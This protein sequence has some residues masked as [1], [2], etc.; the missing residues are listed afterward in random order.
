V[1]AAGTADLTPRSLVWATDLDVLPLNHEVR[2]RDGYLV[3]RSPSNPT[4]YWGNLLLFDQPPAVGDRDRWER[5]FQAEFADQPLTRHRAF[6]WDQTQDALGLARAEFLG[7]GYTLER[8]V[9]LVAAA[10]RIRPHARANQEVTTRPLAPRGDEPLWDQVVEMQVDG[11]DAQRFTEDAHRSF[12]RRRQ[13]DLRDLFAAGRGDWYV[14]LNGDEV[15]GSCG[16]VVTGGRGR[17][18]AV[19]TAPAH[20][21]RGICSRLL[22]D[23]ARHAA[24]RHGA[25]RLVIVADPDYHALG[26]Y[27][28]LGFE[29]AERVCGVCL[30][31]E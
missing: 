1:P 12:T 25:G 24:G 4:H 13:A 29:P 21:R 15:L 27:R 2:R 19:D 23:A 5:R 10:E 8:N 11:R 16:I 22:V 9:G 26:I 14:A 3:V 18:Q 30:G 7:H 17:Y 28:S 31:D 20:R 6:G